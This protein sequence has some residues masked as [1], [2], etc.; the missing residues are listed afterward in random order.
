MKKINIIISALF[1]ILPLLVNA[2][3]RSDRPLEM[4]F[5]QSDFFF[6]PSYVN[7][8]GAENFVSATVLTSDHPLIALQRNPA[9]LAA[10]DRDT[11]PSNFL[12]LDFRNN[13]DIVES[14][15]P[16]YYGIRH[17]YV[18][19]GWGYY[20]TS[21]RGEI[22]PLISAAYLARLPLLNNSIT[23]GATYQLISQAENYYAIPHEIYRNVAGTTVEGT[24]Y[25]GM[26]DYDIT[27]RFTGSDEMYHEGH[28]INTFL[29]W[30]VSDEVDVG[31]KVGRFLFIREGSLGS[32]NLWNHRID[33][34]SYW[35]RYE[36]R[37]Q[38]YNHWD[39]LLGITYSTNDSRLG[40]HAGLVTGNVTQNLGRDD[41][42][43]S[44]RGESGD[45]NRSHYQ[46]WHLTDQ[47]WDHN[48]NRFYSGLLWERQLREDLGFRFMYN[49]SHLSQSLGLSS[50]IERESE[51]EYYSESSNWLYE[52]EG[53]SNM[54]DF[55]TGNGDRI[56]NNH[57]AR[58]AMNWN[59]QE[60][61]NLSVGIILGLRNQSTKTSEKVDAF[62]ETYWYWYRESNNDTYTTERY[63][64]TIEDKT[65]IWEFDSRLRSVQ[66]PV[67]CE[68]D[69]NERFDIMIGINR[70]MNFWKI[71]NTTLILY[72]Y[73]E[74]VENDQTLI[75]TMTGERITE[76]TERLSI[77]NT[78]FIGS[79]TFFPSASFSV[80]L[81]ISPGFEDH[82]LRDEQYAGMHY[83]LSMN[84]RL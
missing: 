20:H 56:I 80:Q 48:A 44:K 84:L 66:I 71:D 36:G 75:E 38:D 70:T 63:Y 39:Y 25:K 33:Y 3:Y 14:R 67:I 61:H 54:H 72:D 65:I 42:S 4:T 37:D 78:N 82:S 10:F 74:R 55:R 8:L 13:R 9:N 46:S 41:G 53:F 40:L 27:D 31:I 12:Y 49:Y 83:W 58:A 34:Q 73:R 51:N 28:T 64:K 47:N 76:P 16:A 26:E 1:L 11:L 62:S 29:A 2:Q 19:P 43:M 18:Y 35:K 15:Y 5:E 57:L 77:T 50:S 68:Y 17:G 59:V 7:P 23:F 52:S 32:D 30:E 69:I 6:S 21:V 79:I 24:S 22:T 81:T 45:S 60:N